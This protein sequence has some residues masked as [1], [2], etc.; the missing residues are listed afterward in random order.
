MGNFSGVTLVTYD[1]MRNTLCPFL[2]QMAPLSS[3]TTDAI[4]TQLDNITQDFPGLK[5]LTV[6]MSTDNAANILKTPKGLEKLNKLNDRFLGHVPCLLQSINRVNGTLFE[7]SEEGRDDIRSYMESRL[8]EKYALECQLQEDG[9]KIGN[10]TADSFFE[11]LQKTQNIDD[12]LTYFL[13]GDKILRKNNELAYEIKTSFIKKEIFN[14]H[15]QKHQ[16]AHAD[17]DLRLKSYCIT[18]WVSAIDTLQR[19]KLLKPVLTDLGNDQTFVTKF[20][21]E[22]FALADDLLKFIEPFQVLCETL[23]RDN[24]TVKFAIPL[25]LHYKILMEQNDIEHLKSNSVNFQHTKHL[26][27]FTEKMKKYYHKYTENKVCEI[28]SFLCINFVNSKF[29]PAKY[30]GRGADGKKTSF[31]AEMLSKKI[32]EAIIPFL[33]VHYNKEDDFE[34]QVVDP[35]SSFIAGFDDTV[36][37]GSIGAIDNSEEVGAGNDTTFNKESIR[38][39][40]EQL[41]FEEIIEYCA[42]ADQERR[43]CV[44]EFAQTNKFPSMERFKWKC[45]TIVGADNIFWK[46]FGANFPILSFANRLF[47]NIPASSIYVERLF[48]VAS[49][50]DAKKKSQQSNKMLENLC[51]LK[52][53][54]SN[55]SLEEINLATCNL[56]DAIEVTVAF[57]DSEEDD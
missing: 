1:E 3:H 12:E 48:G 30:P 16:I 25:L 15:C 42:K 52:S 5:S 34:N 54:R 56:K 2:L 47:R 45:S 20:T 31:I 53:F 41:I 21:K 39:D 36:D 22:D 55:I 38:T 29:W 35:N 57:S 43:N 23:S 50:I 26:T 51:I 7:S 11:S 13:S 24:C 18:R 14:S 32:S 8:M 19:I 37:Q 28:S 44:K 17:N 6:A 9:S 40:L 46:K 49:M 4:G 27:Q 10:Y 33:N